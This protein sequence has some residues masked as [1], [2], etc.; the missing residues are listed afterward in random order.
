MKFFQVTEI[1]EP[2]PSFEKL[3]S[4]NCLDSVFLI[5]FFSAEDIF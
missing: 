5:K 3:T 2:A 4:V 1:N